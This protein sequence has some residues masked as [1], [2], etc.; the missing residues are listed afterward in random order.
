[1][2]KYLLKQLPYIQRM[3]V[4]QRKTVDPRS[5][6]ASLKS[7]SSPQPDWTEE[8]LTVSPAFLD[9]AHGGL[10]PLSHLQDSLRLLQGWPRLFSFQERRLQIALPAPSQATDPPQNDS[11]E[12]YTAIQITLLGNVQ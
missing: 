4:G 5:S 11:H 12:Y 7:G 2:H 9:T 10:R 3:D 1:M 6:K 8:G